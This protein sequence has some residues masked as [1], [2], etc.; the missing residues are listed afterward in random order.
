[1]LDK[2][3]FYSTGKIIK[4]IE[5]GVDACCF[6]YLND[7]LLLIGCFDGNYL[8]L[9]L[10]DFNISIIEKENNY[11]AC[12]KKLDNK[13]LVSGLHNGVMKIYDILE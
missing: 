6:E 11:I 7:S 5:I 12:M 10:K 8:A 9:N 2:I 13:I 3:I 4:E 1:M